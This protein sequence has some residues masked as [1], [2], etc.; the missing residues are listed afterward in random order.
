MQKDFEPFTPP[1]VASEQLPLILPKQPEAMQHGRSSFE[2]EKPQDAS[3]QAAPCSPP[4]G[5]TAS[6]VARPE[7]Q[8][9][10]GAAHFATSTIPAS[11]HT[12]TAASLPAASIATPLPVGAR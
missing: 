6:A 4:V 1:L 11:G 5:S 10:Q 3:G 12:S 9:P 7:P 8:L 2:F